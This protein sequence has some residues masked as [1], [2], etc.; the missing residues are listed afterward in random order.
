MSRM[1]VPNSVDAFLK[2]RTS[3]RTG[4]RLKWKDNKPPRVDVWM[5]K[6]VI[7]IALWSHQFPRLVVRENKKEDSSKTEVWGG[8]LNCREDESILI[9]Q[10]KRND[11][12]TRRFP[13]K[14]CPVCKL[15]ETVRDMIEEEQ[16][17]WTQTI[18]RFD[19]D[20]DRRVLHAGGLCGM[21][22]DRNDEMSDED[23]K[24][25]K[26]AGIKMGG[27]DG[28]WREKAIAKCAYVFAV[29]DNDDVG[30]GIQI[31]TEAQSL[32]DKVKDV[33]NDTIESLENN[34]VGNPFQT[35]YVIRWE[36]NDAKGIPYDKIYKARRMEKIVL[37]EDID[38]LISSER[39]DLS[40][41]TALP[42]MKSLRA[43]LERHCTVKNMPWDHIFDVQGGDEEE[44][45]GTKFPPEESTTKRERAAARGRLPEVSTKTKEKPAPKSEPEFN[46]D[47]TDAG[48]DDGSED[49][50]ICKDQDACPHVGCDDCGK[51]ILPTDAKCKHCG[52]VY[53][54]AT[55]E[56][57]K[58]GTG[59]KRATTKETGDRI[60]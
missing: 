16:L 33:I 47:D 5:H 6:L 10:Y 18:F 44:D 58:K 45:E 57:E 2:H 38:K 31:T 21:Y 28:A 56:P 29:V 32:G 59:R 13:P 23:K 26:D 11:D 19:G 42:N 49:C 25:L 55:P 35:P 8:T 12:G 43:T 9:R 17:D 34:I 22:D 36:Y 46:G 51:P 53:K 14:S 48:D 37:T 15:I 52:K 1:M 39:P 30:A 60:E 54:A 27:D 7:P 20:E 40:H 3:E 24:E 50:P 4:G 41:V